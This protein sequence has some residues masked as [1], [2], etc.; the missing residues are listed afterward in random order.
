MPNVPYFFV[1]N[2]ACALNRNI[3]RPCGASNLNVKTRVT[4]IACAEHEYM[5]NVLLEF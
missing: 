1:G 5:W 4:T 3:L 2:E